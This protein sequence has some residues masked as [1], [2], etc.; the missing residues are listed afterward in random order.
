[1][2]HLKQVLSTE[3]LRQLAESTARG[4]AQRDCFH[5][6]YHYV[7][8]RFVAAHFE[9]LAG[10]VADALRE[11]R[12]GITARDLTYVNDFVAPVNLATAQTPGR[13]PKYL[14]HNDIIDRVLS[15]CYNLW[16]P[17]YRRSAL[18]GLDDQSIL[19]VLTPAGCPRLYDADGAL[20]CTSHPWSAA[21]LQPFD[22]AIFAR[23][24]GIP[25]ANLNDYWFYHD[26]ERLEKLPPAELK[27]VLVKRPQLG[28]CCVFDS[29]FLHASG[30][31]GFERVGISIKFLVHNPELGFRV[32][33]HSSAPFA[34]GGWWGMFI[35]SYEQRGT[36]SAYRD[37][38]EMYLERERPLLE[39]DA[40]KLECLRAVLLEAAR[41]LGAQAGQS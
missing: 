6:Q 40:D 10:L 41:D 15:P 11:A 5:D 3:F 17:L 16:I 4:I 19:E 20:K 24:V 2:F 36:F 33:R 30:A 1:V 26:G 9:Q 38:L 13:F 28:D 12:P 32:L 37:V 23:L 22:R 25:V 21:M 35:S 29:S 14:W 31:S 7:N 39:R 18:A 34:L 27:P 8:R